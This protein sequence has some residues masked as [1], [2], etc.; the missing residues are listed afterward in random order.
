VRAFGR[1]GAWAFEKCH[2]LR[3]EDRVTMPE[4]GLYQCDEAIAP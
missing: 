2:Q 4:I 1:V 3:R